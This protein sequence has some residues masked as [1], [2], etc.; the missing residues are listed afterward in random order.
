MSKKVMIIFFSIAVLLF[1]VTAM[2]TPNLSG[3]A[4]YVVRYYDG[5][6]VQALR[7]IN[8]SKVDL[9]NGFSA[10]INFTLMESHLLSEF[11]AKNCKAPAFLQSNMANLTFNEAYIDYNSANMELKAGRFYVNWGTSPVENPVNLLE[12][13]DFTDIFNSPI[14]NS[15]VGVQ[16]TFWYND[17][18][19]LEVDLI[20]N[21]SPN[22]YPT[23]PSSVEFIQP[24]PQNVQIGLRYSTMI[25]D[26]NIYLDAYHGFEH[27]FGLINAKLTYP[28]LNAIGAEFSGPFPINQDYNLYGECA[29][30]ANKKFLGLMGVNGFISNTMVGIELKRGLPGESLENAENSILFYANKNINDIWKLNSAIAL[31]FASEN[32]RMEKGVFVDFDASYQ[33]IQNLSID[34]GGEYMNGD[35]QEYFGLQK[36]KS[37]VYVKGEIYF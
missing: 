29:L 18:S 37:G 27:S 28:R 8:I 2:A 35:P 33:P 22:I 4:G 1:G 25:G 24:L 19:S 32:S 11:F 3:K 7:D 36:S 31:S 14:R 26:Y 23:I 5:K 17:G 13:Y 20:P 21:F 10:K 12:A 6:I 15:I 9:G 34:F 16:N 30:S